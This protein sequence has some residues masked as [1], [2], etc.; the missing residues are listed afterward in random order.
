M[1]NAQR[2]FENLKQELSGYR[3]ENA[4]SL[5][6]DK[7]DYETEPETQKYLKKFRESMTPK[8][9][10]TALDNEVALELSIVKGGKE[11]SN[12]DGNSKLDQNTELKSNQKSTKQEGD[13][14]SKQ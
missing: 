2:K 12:D 6:G 3:T 4:N 13:A 8:L 1:D 10:R 5:A 9:K 7:N 11:Q 14:S